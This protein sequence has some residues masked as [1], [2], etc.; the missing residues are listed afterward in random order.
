M[1]T[2][3]IWT[4]DNLYAPF[5]FTEIKKCN[6]RNVRFEAK[7]LGAA[8]LDVDLNKYSVDLRDQF[9]SGNFTDP[10]LNDIAANKY[11]FIQN[12]DMIPESVDVTDPEY[13][14][15]LDPVSDSYVLPNPGDPSVFW[16]GYISARSLEVQ[17][18]SNDMKGSL[19]CLEIGHRINKFAVRHPK[20]NKNGFNPKVDGRWIGNKKV[21]AQAGLFSFNTNPLDMGTDPE[22]HASKY[23]T[24]RQV[25]DYLVHYGVP[26]QIATD[27]SAVEDSYAVGQPN[28]WIEGFEE[29]PSY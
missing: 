16:W 28:R 3:R 4:C 9:S 19:E 10:G 25:V 2:Y 18:R 29:I 20:F 14:P 22:A 21:V 8:Q 1:T 11:I 13:D 12:A 27:W 6:V 15:T 7:G 17:A 24:I 5:N 23:W 26:Y